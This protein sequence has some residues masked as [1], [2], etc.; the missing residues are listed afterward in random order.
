M[1]HTPVVAKKKKKKKEEEE[2]KKEKE[3]KKKKETQHV[4]TGS[5]QKTMQYA[6]RAPVA[7]LPSFHLFSGGTAWQRHR[8]RAPFEVNEFRVAHRKSK[9]LNV[10]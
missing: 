5:S 6:C 8:A 10:C 4:H 9:L 1:F 3:K 2:E 7:P